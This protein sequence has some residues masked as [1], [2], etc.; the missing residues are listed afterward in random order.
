MSC[1]LKFPKVLLIV[2]R[3]GAEFKNLQESKD[4][5]QIIIFELDNFHGFWFRLA[6]EKDFFESGFEAKC[7]YL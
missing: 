5:F 1:V 3:A 6:H 7:V 2:T 4:L